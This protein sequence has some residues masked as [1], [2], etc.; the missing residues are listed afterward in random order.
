MRR[1]EHAFFG[2]SQQIGNR[3]EHHSSRLSSG[4]LCTRSSARSGS[5]LKL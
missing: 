1:Q 5:S 3:L 4:Q 2:L